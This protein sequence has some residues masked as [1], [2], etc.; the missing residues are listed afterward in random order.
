MIYRI[1]VLSPEVIMMG[2]LV[3]LIFLFVGVGLL[4][5][6]HFC[7]GGGP[8]RWTFAPVNIVPRRS[9]CYNMPS[10]DLGKLPC[11]NFKA[12]E[13]DSNPVDCAVC[14][15]N[16]KVGDRCRLLPRCNHSFHS[17]CID[18]WLL[19]TPICP[20]C[21]TSANL[22]KSCMVSGEGSSHPGEVGFEFRESQQTAGGIQLSSNTS[23]LQ[24]SP[25]EPVV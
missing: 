24:N 23:P 22:K 19:K 10:V 5:L 13:K 2:I 9:T 1:P 7:V 25:A 6:V 12:E 18:S 3:C 17:Q 8:Y 15:E 4:L 20:I 16:L 21:R 11:Y 14:L